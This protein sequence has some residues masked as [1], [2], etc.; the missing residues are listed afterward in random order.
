MDLWYDASTGKQHCDQ[1]RWKTNKVLTA[2]VQIER[3]RR[4]E[5][6]KF[7]IPVVIGVLGGGIKITIYEVKKIFK[8]DDLSK[9]IVGEMQRTILM[10]G[11]IIIHKIL[12][13]LVQTD[14]S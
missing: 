7:V 11:E 12:S 5:Y 14:F 13:G 3:E 4:V 9:K 6:K 1:T 2:R 10:D 8:Q